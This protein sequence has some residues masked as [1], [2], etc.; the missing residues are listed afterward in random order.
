MIGKIYRQIRQ[1]CQIL[2]ISL[3]FG[4]TQL[5]GLGG[6]DLQALQK[7]IIFNV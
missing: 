5:F 1:S 4:K 6:L 7:S 2:L 3:S